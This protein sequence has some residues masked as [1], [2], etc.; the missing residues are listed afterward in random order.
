M[1]SPQDFEAW[2][3]AETLAIAQAIAYRQS[4]ENEAFARIHDKVFGQPHQPITP[5][6]RQAQ[7]LGGTTLLLLQVE[8]PTRQET[9]REISGR[10]EDEWYERQA[11][12]L[13]RNGWEISPQN[14]RKLYMT[15]ADELEARAGTPTVG[16]AELFATLLAAAR[17]VAEAHDTDV[18]MVYIDDALYVEAARR[19][20][21]P[22]MLIENCEEA[23]RDITADAIRALE[24]TMMGS[25]DFADEGRTPEDRA[26]EAMEMQLDPHNQEINEML[27][28]ILR[29]ISL[30]F[31]TYRLATFWGA[32]ML[33]ELWRERRHLKPNGPIPRFLYKLVCPDAPDPT[34]ED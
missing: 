4:I 2:L 21:T 1:S 13:S 14:F 16:P 34:Y 24:L 28:E 17:E 19:A 10:H 32:D 15:L 5:E 30:Q 33:E 7:V 22:E 6:T 29:E 18:A 26:L 31:L 23:T 27:V 20:Y 25:D 9:F 12:A 11:G 3:P 8:D